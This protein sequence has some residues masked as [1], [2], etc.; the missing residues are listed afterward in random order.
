MGPIDASWHIL[1]FFGPALG[2]GLL[3]PLLAKLLWRHALR[4]ASLARL[5]GWV[6]VAC[7]TAAI[8]GLAMFG[9]DGKMATYAAMVLVC[10]LTLWWVGFS[11]G[12]R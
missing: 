5:C 8:V 4:G 9:H 2:M 3:A 12:P 7:T 1:N 11:S 6:S 10:S